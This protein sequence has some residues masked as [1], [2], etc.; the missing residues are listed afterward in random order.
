MWGPTGLTQAQLDRALK[1]IET[2]MK[3]RGA[4][5]NL[6][7]ARTLPTAAKENAGAGLYLGRAMHAWLF[8]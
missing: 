5:M 6:I 4:A 7:R 8:D 1:D 2:A 3:A